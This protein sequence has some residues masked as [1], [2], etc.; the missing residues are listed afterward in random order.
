MSTA[1]APATIRSRPATAPAGATTPAPARPREATAPARTR[2][3]DATTLAPARP[4]DTGAPEQQQS[5][6]ALGGEVLDMF[7]GAVAALMPFILLSMP[8]IVL[9]V[10]FPLILIAI[11]AV[12]LGVLLTPPLLVGLLVRRWL[13]GAGRAGR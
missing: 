1:S 13:T 11:P 10:I 3:A 2:P 5:L 8:A 9:F 4:R 6:L 12:V 7:A